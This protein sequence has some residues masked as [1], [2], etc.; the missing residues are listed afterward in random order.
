MRWRRK[1]SLRLALNVYRLGHGIDRCFGSETTK[2][3]H[4]AGYK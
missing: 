4:G 2:A 3:S 1:R